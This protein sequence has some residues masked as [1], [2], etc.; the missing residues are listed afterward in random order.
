V[1]SHELN[2]DERTEARLHRGSEEIEPIKAVLATG[3]RHALLYCARQ[4]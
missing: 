1:V 2:D 4:A 3:R